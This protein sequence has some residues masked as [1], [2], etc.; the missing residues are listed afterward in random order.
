MTDFTESIIGLQKSLDETEALLKGG[1]GSGPH[2]G[3]GS[4]ED[5]THQA[6]CRIAA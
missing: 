2:P 4:P 3:G 5:K 6:Y 1:P